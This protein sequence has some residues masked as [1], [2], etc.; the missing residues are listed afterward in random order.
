MRKYLHG[1]E[2]LTVADLSNGYIQ[3]WQSVWYVGRVPVTSAQ[4]DLSRDEH[5]TCYWVKVAKRAYV[6]APLQYEDYSFLRL[7]DARRAWS[8]FVRYAKN[9]T[10]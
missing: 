8:R 3:R 5:K 2:V 4:V 1:V 9:G 10:L 7:A 6:F